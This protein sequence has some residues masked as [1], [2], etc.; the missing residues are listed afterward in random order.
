MR[1]GHAMRQGGAPTERDY[2]RKRM[3]QSLNDLPEVLRTIV[4]RPLF[5]MRL[6]VKPY[7]VLGPTPGGFRRVGVVPGGS[8]DGDRLSGQVPEGGNDWQ[9]VR[10]DSAVTLDVRLVLKTD[11]Q[12]LIGMTYKGIRHGPPEVIAR[13]DKGEEVH[14]SAYHFRINPIFETASPKYD[15]INRVLA[16]GVGYRR[17]KDVVY[18]VFEIL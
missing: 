4:G 1:R 13:L 8:F 10:G 9:F 18:S 3:S 12:E 7:Q 15:W 6:D 2:R 17:A 16:I 11:D 14:P 5:V